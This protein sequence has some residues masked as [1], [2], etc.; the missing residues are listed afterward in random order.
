L[1]SH[2]QCGALKSVQSNAGI[3]RIEQSVER[4]AARLR[5]SSHR[6]LGE[7]VM[8]HGSFDLIGKDLFDR[9]LFVLLEHALLGKKIIE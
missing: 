4:S 1:A 3:C 8:F 5:A 2:R 6:S 9:A 7:T